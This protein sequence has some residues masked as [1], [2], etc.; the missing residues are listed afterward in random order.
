MDPAPEEGITG[1]SPSRWSCSPFGE[2]PPSRIRPPP[3]GFPIA[4]TGRNPWSRQPLDRTA[5]AS[6]MAKGTAHREAKG[7]RN[8]GESLRAF[9]R[10]TPERPSNS[11]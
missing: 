8:N 7:I 4:I 11:P 2:L 1:E 6:S 3:D 9:P 5:G 10:N